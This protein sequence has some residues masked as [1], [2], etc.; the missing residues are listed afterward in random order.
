[1]KSSD[2]DLS[3]TIGE[4]A[5]RFDLRPHVLRH[6]EASGL[7]S[8]AER[9][10]GRRRYTKRHIARVAMI[11][12]GKAAGFSLEQL[13]DVLDAGNADARQVL[14]RAHYEELERRIREIEAS[15]TLIEH[16]M[17]CRAH[18]FTE[19]PG[20]SRLVESL[21]EGAADAEAYSVELR[22]HVH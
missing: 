17:S 21:N 20:F 22:G 13:R 2:A 5:E 12:R 6:W 11:V 15:R 18:D 9:V 1:M 7:L 16:A 14:L 10:N 3:M 4:L 19:C 8:P